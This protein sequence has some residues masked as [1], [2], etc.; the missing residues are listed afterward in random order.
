MSLCDVTGSAPQSKLQDL[1]A[2]ELH[3]SLVPLVLAPVQHS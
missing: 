1:L 3:E 2:Q